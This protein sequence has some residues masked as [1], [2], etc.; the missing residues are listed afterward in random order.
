MIRVR[1]EKFYDLVDEET[2]A[3]IMKMD[4]DY[5]RSVRRTHIQV[6]DPLNR[7]SH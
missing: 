7:A 6:S 3:K 1:K 2:K 5:P 4:V